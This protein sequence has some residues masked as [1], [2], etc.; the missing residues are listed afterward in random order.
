MWVR[1]GAGVPVA[2]TEKLN[3]VPAVAVAVLALFMARPL[4]TTRVKLWV[5]LPVAV[6]VIVIG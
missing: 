1:V 4:F 3:A 2:V 6:A 5:A